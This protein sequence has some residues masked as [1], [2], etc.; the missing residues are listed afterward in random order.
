MSISTELSQQSLS[1]LVLINRDGMGSA[2]EE[3]RYKLLSIYLKML[4]ENELFPGAICFYADGVKMVVHDSPIL[5]LLRS[6]EAKG[7][8]IIICSTC[9]QHFGLR[10]KVAVG[11]VGGMHDIVLAQWM[12]SKVITL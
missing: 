5:D 12:A 2:E 3:L 11:V 10:D 9:L 6:L 4:L 7:V 1:T 8:H